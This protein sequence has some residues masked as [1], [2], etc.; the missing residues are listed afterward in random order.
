MQQQTQEKAKPA[1][2]PPPSWKNNPDRK[3]LAELERQEADAALHKDYATAEKLKNQIAQLRATLKANQ[4]VEE[5]IRD[6]E[7]QEKAAADDKDYPKAGAIQAKIEKLRK[8]ANCQV[9]TTQTFNQPPPPSTPPTG[10]THQ[11]PAPAPAPLHKPASF[12]YPNNKPTP[13]PMPVKNNSF[14]IQRDQ[15][16]GSSSSSSYTSGYQY[17]QSSTSNTRPMT[18]APSAGASIAA[19][20]QAQ[21]GYGKSRPPVPPKNNSYN[22]DLTNS[23]LS[24]LREE[25]NDTRPVDTGMSNYKARGLGL[26]DADKTST[27][28]LRRLQKMTGKKKW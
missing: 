6:L 7:Q 9:R 11:A 4:D 3:S 26:K 27:P 10:Y 18:L 1:L 20:V 8:T 22:R 25:F 2:P 28:T 12:S 13:P 19:Q 23:E 17:P 15:V 14:C 16:Q 5:L 21:T 24:G